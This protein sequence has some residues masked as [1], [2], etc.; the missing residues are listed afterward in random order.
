M[1]EPWKRPAKWKKVKH[2]QQQLVWFCS[3]EMS[4][5]GNTEAENKL[6]VVRDW[7]EEEWRTATNRYKISSQGDRNDLKLDSDDHC[8]TLQMYWT[9]PTVPFKRMNFMICELQLNKSVTL[10]TTTKKPSPSTI[11]SGLEDY[12]KMRLRW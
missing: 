1:D 7:R 6:G 12:Y 9:P 8:T 5:T 11:F 2:N 10:I 4:K 3:S